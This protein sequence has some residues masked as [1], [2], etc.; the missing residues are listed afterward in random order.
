MLLGINANNHDA[1][2]ALVKNNNILD[3]VKTGNF[4]NNNLIEYARLYKEIFDYNQKRFRI[5]NFFNI[6]KFFICGRCKNHL[7]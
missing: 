2:I 3:N 7:K 5:K 6:N 4:N 1:S